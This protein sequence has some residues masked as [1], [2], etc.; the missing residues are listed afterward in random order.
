MKSPKG[1]VREGISNEAVRALD[2]SKVMA[3]AFAEVGAQWRQNYIEVI[4]DLSDKVL[5]LFGNFGFEA[6]G[7]RYTGAVD[8]DEI[9][10]SVPFLKWFRGTS[11]DTTKRGNFIVDNE[12]VH[13]DAMVGNHFF[14][15][16]RLLEGFLKRLGERHICEAGIEVM[17][18]ILS[19]GAEAYDEKR[20][21]IIGAIVGDI[22]GSRFEWHNR[23]SKKF[24]LMKGRDES[25]H[26]CHFTDDTVMTL[27]VAKALM[28]WRVNGGDLHILSVQ[29]M[30]EF[31]RIYPCAGYGGAFR[32]W[33]QADA[34]RPYNSW[35][36]GSA[37]RVSACGWA[38]RTLDEVKAMSRAV[39]EVTHNHPEG[40]KGAEATA[41]ATFLARTGKSMEE[42]KA[43]V[44]R[45][46]YPLRF[47]LDG[48]RPTYAFDVSCQG[49]V[50]QA[51]E[52]FFES[53]SFEDAIRNA[54]SI[55]GDSDTIGAICGAVA[56]AYYGVPAEIRAKAET[57][58]DVRLLETLHA[59]E[60]EFCVAI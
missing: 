41:V 44:V 21:G 2:V 24:T 28:D 29:R 45:D 43:V 53:T 30:Q 39:T 16:G 54:I 14:I 31:G 11:I 15:R 50:P 10:R 38:G 32:R 12:W 23:K 33:L 19:N 1:V 42:I 3:I 37:M 46:Y 5:V 57:F 47:T 35:G 27:A 4:S 13:L 6:Y 17:A 55:G 8:I 26:P 60:R 36:N 20:N 49:S 9:E 40:I 25:R 18:D 48:I 52:A 58:L 7:K 34:P 56:G 51:L 22:V 59:F